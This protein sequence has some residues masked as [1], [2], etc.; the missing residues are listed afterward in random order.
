MQ[1]IT[2][3]SDKRLAGE[4][5]RQVHLAA[6]EGLA[7]TGEASGRDADGT[8]AGLP[9]SNL[10]GTLCGVKNKGPFWPQADKPDKTSN[11]GTTV[12][13]RSKESID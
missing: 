8:L 4:L 1:Y 5:E 7:G 11:N 9:G 3:V 6:D 10:Y 13:I 2:F 12:M